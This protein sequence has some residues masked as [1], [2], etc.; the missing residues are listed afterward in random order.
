[1]VPIAEYATVSAD[2]TLFEAV[3]VLQ[4]AQEDWDR[5]KS[6]YIHRA[7]LI[8]DK[9]KKIVGK[10]SQMEIL[11]ALEPRYEKLGD[12]KSMSR[13]GLSPAF[14]KSMMTQFKLWEKP[15]EAI[16]R[17]AS[18]VKVKTFMH[19]PTMGEYVEENASLNEAI[20][21][22]IVGQHQSLLVTRDKEI[23]GIIKLTDVYNAV[24]LKIMACKI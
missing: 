18:Q 1:M 14:L 6:P 17:K 8:F 2:A 16:C 21:Q 20:H 11:M 15:L 10:V 9:D 12:A 22:L 5:D 7:V 24:A 4:R 23:V 19:T 3:A 13:F